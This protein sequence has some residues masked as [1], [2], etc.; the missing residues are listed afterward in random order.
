M[1]GEEKGRLCL[2]FSLGVAG[3]FPGPIGLV[4]GA[5]RIPG[6]AA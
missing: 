2:P 1:C 3:R 4:I 6:E 5:S